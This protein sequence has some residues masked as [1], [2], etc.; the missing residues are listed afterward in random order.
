M[1]D[2]E[3][4]LYVET[5]HGRV[6]IELK[7]DLAPAMLVAL[8]NWPA[9]AFTMGLFSTASLMALWPRAAVPMAPAW[10]AL[11]SLILKLNSIQKNTCA[12]PVQWPAHKCPTAPIASFSSA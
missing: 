2:L 7:A 6:V 10:A 8:K 4:T 9:K 3:N 5:D 11:P 1:S 12:A